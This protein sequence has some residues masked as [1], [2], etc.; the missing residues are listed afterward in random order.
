MVGCCPSDLGQFG[1]QEAPNTISNEIIAISPWRPE[2]EINSD[3]TRKTLNLGPGP[4]IAHV[5]VPSVQALLSTTPRA[6]QQPRGSGIWTSHLALIF[7]TVIALPDF[8]RHVVPDDHAAGIMTPV[9]APR[10]PRKISWACSVR[11]DRARMVLTRAMP[12]MR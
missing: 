7:L 12:C 9:P 10:L 4:V 6:L 11:D 5:T 3:K 1:H 8:P 2:G